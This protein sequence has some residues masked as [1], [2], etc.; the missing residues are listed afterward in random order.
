MNRYPFIPFTIGFVVGIILGKL[1]LFD[2]TLFVYVFPSCLI[3]FV[4]ILYKIKEYLELGNIYLI[5][6]L[7]IVFF[8]TVYFVFAHSQ[9][10]EYP[11]TKTHLTNAVIYGRI[12]SI[13]LIKKD[14]IELTLSVDSVKTAETLYKTRFNALC[15]IS[16]ESFH[17]INVFYNGLGIGNYL[18]VRGVLAKPQAIRNPGDFDYEKYLYS[19]KLSALIYVNKLENVFV[20]DSNTD[21]IENLIFTLRKN[22]DSIL[23][24]YHTF[25]TY[26]L[27][28]S[29][30]LAD[31][32]ELDYQ[33][34]RKY[35]NAGVVHVLAVSGLHVGFIV[36]IF[37]LLFNRFNL[38]LKYFFTITGVIFFMILT[39]AQPPVFRASVMA[40]I[41]IVALFTNRSTNAYNSLAIA[42]F[43]ILFVNPQELF[44]PGFQLSFSAVLSIVYFYPKIQNQIYSKF[45]EDN[46]LRKILL[47]AA[48]SLS[49]QIG[50]LP[51][52]LLYFHKLSLIAILVNVLIIPAIGF[53]LGLGIVVVLISFVSEWLAIAYA[54]VNCWFVN[55]LNRLIKSVGST[56]YSY[57][58]IH[59][60]SAYDTLLFYLFLFIML[61]S[62]TR[63]QNRKAK[64][65]LVL[66][67]AINFVVFSRLDDS[68]LLAQNKLNIMIFDAGEG[69]SVLFNSGEYS[70]L[71]NAGKKDEFFDFGERVL[72]PFITRNEISKINL[73]LLSNVKRELYG[74]F[75]SLIKNKKVERILKPQRDTLNEEENI[76]EEYFSYYKVNV[77][78]LGDKVYSI[79]N[80]KLY[81]LVYEKTNFLHTKK[82]GI[83]I[84]S[85]GN[86]SVLLI[87]L[88]LP[89]SFYLS[90]NIWKKLNT[91]LVV[92]RLKNNSLSKVYKFITEIQPEILVLNYSDKFLPDESFDTQNIFGNNIIVKNVCRSGAILLRSDGINV[93]QIDWQTKY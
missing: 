82:N 46:L 38:Y 91:K 11:F 3:L 69:Q 86:I 34:K 93:E 18:Q 80:I 24:K 48:V 81:P 21:L 67:A 28:R 59:N 25:E 74:G 30:L 20:V 79:G 50:T 56:N 60:F 9:K 61:I 70:V 27:L 15:K 55:V 7:S 75:L 72:Q 31:R 1:Y 2:K 89:K 68:Q 49:A 71:V 14:K 58:D 51:F 8:G 4:L 10:K 85:Y 40:I 17:N 64:I 63:F 44:N 5:F 33:L 36:L 6:F 65:I 16:D 84:I 47:F 88:M 83:F 37:M 92:L 26:A 57:L 77:D 66:L 41:I 54:S 87:D 13:E 12:K 90:E 29:L 42:A 73:G 53:V 39:G 45:R 43:I 32:G 23:K 76:L 78:Y 62:L 35:V 19:K 22:I 52:T